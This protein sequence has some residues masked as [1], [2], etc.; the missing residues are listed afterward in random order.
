MDFNLTLIDPPAARHTHFLF[1]LAKMIAY[2]IEDLGHSCTL[3]RNVTEP[4]RTNILLG[5]HNLT[6]PETVD[7]LIDSRHPYI[8]YQ[9]EIIRGSTINGSS[10]N[11]QFSTLFLP[12]LQN[13]KAVWDTEAES[14]AALKALGIA[15]QKLGFGYT[16][17]LEEVRHRDEKD[18]DF[19]FYGSMTPHRQEVL[20]K[21]R[22]LGYQVAVIFDDA[23]M[24][25]NDLL[26]RSEVVLTLRQSEKFAH[27]PQA[28]ILYLI[29]N[30]CLVAGES[31]LGQEPLEDLFLWSEPDQVIE[32]LRRTRAMKNRRELAGDFHERFK[33]RPMTSH[34][35]PLI[36]ALQ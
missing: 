36:E 18:I 2:G 23:A 31:G 32:L 17:R 27:L 34:L 35:E 24:F 7:E 12:L 28:R 19:F 11:G 16:P 30:R 5:A 20:T 4:N 10:L 6:A 25:R 3:R 29:N 21:L 9:T 15:T 8:V 33:E 1:E 26:S 13:A 22:G 14:I